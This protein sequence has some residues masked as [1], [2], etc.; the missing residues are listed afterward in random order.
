MIIRCRSIVA[1][2][3]I[4]G[5]GG[6]RAFG[7]RHN[8]AR[9]VAT[10]GGADPSWLTIEGSCMTCVPLTCWFCSFRKRI[11]RTMEGPKNWPVAWVRTVKTAS[12]AMAV[13]VV[14]ASRQAREH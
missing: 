2:A 13:Q 5:T 9:Y 7:C 12:G 14:W 1:S 4:I 8:S 3:S 6:R 10:I 11:L